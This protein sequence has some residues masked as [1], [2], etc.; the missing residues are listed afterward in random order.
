M[1]Y[2]LTNG[3]YP[4]WATFVK[5]I[6]VPQD[7]KRQHFASTQEVARK[8]VEHSFGVLQPCYA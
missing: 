8:D 6:P 1:G 7:H 5:K 2:Y 4:S 3:I